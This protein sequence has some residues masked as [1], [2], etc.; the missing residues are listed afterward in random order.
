MRCSFSGNSL[1]GT[2]SSARSSPTTSPK[3]K[4]SNIGV[5]IGAVVGGIAGLATVLGI[6]IWYLCLRKKKLQQ[7]SFAKDVAEIPGMHFLFPLDFI[8]IFGVL[9]PVGL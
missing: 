4:S 3:K 8:F 1:L 2:N 7:K 9:V 6:L 5:V